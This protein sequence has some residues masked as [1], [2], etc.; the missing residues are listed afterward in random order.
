MRTRRVVLGLLSAAVL[1][2]LV[3]SAAAQPSQGP[4]RRFAPEDIDE[5]MKK[6]TE[7]LQLDEAQAEKVRSVLEARREEMEKLREQSRSRERS[8]E[9]IQEMRREMDKIRQNTEEEL[10]GILSED[11]MKEYRKYEEERLEEMRSRWGG[12]RQPG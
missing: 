4:P 10:G 12:R 5:V 2:C 3:G 11:Q 7:R 8:P 6:L 9:T 1:L